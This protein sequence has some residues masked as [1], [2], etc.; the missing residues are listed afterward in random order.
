M[1]KLHI[2]HGPGQGRSFELDNDT[3][4]VGR[5]SDN[6]I[7]I[8][9][10]SVSRKHLKIVKRDDRFF[11]E[12]LKSTNNTFVNGE[13]V[14]PGK[15]F[16]VEE[17]VP[18][19]VGKVLISLGEMTEED[20]IVI[21][22]S[23]DLSDEFASTGFYRAYKD[24][25]MTTSKNLE[26]IYKVANVL[27]Q[28]LNI[29]ELFEKLMDYLFDLLKRI[30]RGT[31][32]LVDEK[33]GELEQIIARSNYDTDSNFLNYSRTI[34]KK[35]MK[36]GRP[37]NVPDMKKDEVDDFS[38]SMGIIR[39]VLCVPL[40]SRSKVRGV[41]Y[42]DSLDMP[43]GFRKEDV[44]LLTALSGPAA[45][46]IENALL[47]S[48]LEKLVEER[49]TALRET[50]KKLRESEAR[51]KGIF[52]SMSSGVVVY[53]V[54]NDGE[55][56]II[57]DL[58][59]ADQKIEKI[60][61]S[62]VL[63]KSVSELFSGFEVTGLKEVF[64]RVWKTGKPVNRSIKLRQDGKTQGW[65]EYYVYRLPSGEIVSI[66]DDITNRKRAEEEQKDLQRQLFV[67]QK[68]ETIGEFAGG[69]AHNFRNILQAI[70]GNTEYLEMKYGQEAEIKV[71]AESIYN[72]VEKGVGLINNL[73][74][75][76]KKGEDLRLVDL[77]MADVIIKT[78]EIIEKVFN[79]SIEIILDLEKELYVKGNH[80]FL[81]QVFMNLFTNARDAMP[82]G[83]RLL[84]KAKKIKDNVV[85]DVS[86]TGH[87]MDKETLERI[88]DPFF[89][90][91]DVGKGTGLGLSTSHG[92]I[93]Q[94]KGSIS[95]SSKPGKGT[96]FKINLP[97]GKPQEI[98]KPK[99]EKAIVPGHGQRVLIV[100]D[101]HPSLEAL[102]NLTK[103]LGYKPIAVNRAVEALPSYRKW[104]PDVVLMDRGMPEMDGIACIREII[105][106]DPE[107]R[108]VIVSGYEESD[109][110]G[111]DE[112]V[113][114][115]IKGYL[116]KPC[117]GEE[118]SR[119]LFQ[120]LGQ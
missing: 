25:P 8:K 45:V 32:L 50:E 59:R 91:K 6:D 95:V 36:E 90:L 78:Y 28:S 103:S 120:V 35:V 41:I 83:G 42:V 57:L 105:K 29:T 116:T 46:A 22:D 39:S 86:D 17:G 110:G 31:I 87:G 92:I 118:L 53:E 40:I 4:Y 75:F 38:D 33:T 26:L 72:S 3:I 5:S 63:G 107:A 48:D 81:S 66:F 21:K 98:K 108:I 96:T 82:D 97:S 10:N 100:D 58:N 49:T 104:A 101:D 79:K 52:D 37:L 62:E 55:D 84:I 102:T 18:I 11:I 9:D 80:S 64:K 1:T 88:F 99:P 67:S 19:T 51:F 61:K 94:H 109:Q 74:Q 112:D 47:Y 117:G 13:F 60:R 119:M 76:S 68:M 114:G 73:L 43:H 44:S 7:Q 106:T 34:V 30:D 54:T 71:L 14:I 85:V 27:M 111:V 20:T 15:E 70:S 65:R 89:T 24:R 113:K 12:D 56:F 115:M 93:G 77:D 16:K 2:I 23:D 69:T